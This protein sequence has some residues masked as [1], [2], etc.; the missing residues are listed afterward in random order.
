M[1]H[2]VAH[3]LIKFSG[4]LL[5]AALGLDLLFALLVGIQDQGA[6]SLHS[7]RVGLNTSLML[8]TQME[9]P[10]ALLNNPSTPMVIFGWLICVLGWLIVPLLVGVIV[11]VGME[12]DQSESQFRIRLY[13]YLRASGVPEK[14]LDAAVDEA[15]KRMHTINPKD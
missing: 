10:R 11:E 6:F 1:V 4:V 2:R 15:V 5:I 13:R 8:M 7:L 3:L 12:G 14:N 9:P